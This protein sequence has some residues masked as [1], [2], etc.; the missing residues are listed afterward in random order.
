MGPLTLNPPP[1]HTY[2]LR[3]LLIYSG[4]Q[5]SLQLKILG[6]GS[7]FRNENPESVQHCRIKCNGSDAMASEVSVPVCIHMHI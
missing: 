4:T 5:V 6:T 7:K 3:Y 2:L 1:T